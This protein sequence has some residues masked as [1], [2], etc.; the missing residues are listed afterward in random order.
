MSMTPD[1]LDEL[2]L[3]VAEKHRAP[4]GHIQMTATEFIQEARALLTAVEAELKPVGYLFQ[5]G[6]TGITQC[7]EAQQ[8]EWGFEKNNPRLQKVG[9]LI[10]LPLIK[11]KS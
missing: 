7:V 4:Q 9:K 1:R 8:V 2:A 10:S 3:E 11:E 6:E 5:H